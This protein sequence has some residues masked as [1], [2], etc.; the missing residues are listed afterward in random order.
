MYYHFNSNYIRIWFPCIYY[1][2]NYKKSKS[3]S[4]SKSTTGTSEGNNCKEGTYL[5]LLYSENYSGN[6]GEYSESGA[7]QC[8]RCPYGQSSYGNSS[9]LF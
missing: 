2:L 6:P 1:I 8:S 5:N 9:N 3:K 7:Y 4:K